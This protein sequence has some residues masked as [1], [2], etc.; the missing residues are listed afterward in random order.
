MVAYDDVYECEWKRMYVHNEILP[1]LRIT[2][3]QR[4]GRGWYLILLGCLIIVNSLAFHVCFYVYVCVRVSV[5]V[6]MFQ[7]SNGLL[8]TK[9][10]LLNS[11]F[12]SHQ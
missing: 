5:R 4:R 2:R 1:T 12:D 10:T 9:V 7:Q 8:L 11:Y 6:C 3:N